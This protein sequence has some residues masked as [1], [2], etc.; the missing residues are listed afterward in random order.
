[1]N[2]SGSLVFPFRYDNENECLRRAFTVEETVL[3]AIKCFLIT[4][5]GSRVGSNI[6]SFLPELLLQ[7][8]PL[9]KLQTLSDE[10]KNELEGQFPGVTF[11][12]VIFLSELNEKVST[13][14]VSINLKVPTNSNVLELNL[15]LPS[16]FTK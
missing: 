5:K 6:G 7:G 4:R 2:N 12:S 14:K 13:L 8:L 11:L 9:S 10:L 16:L 15:D 3:S 1:M